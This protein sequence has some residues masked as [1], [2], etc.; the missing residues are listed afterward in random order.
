MALVQKVVELLAVPSSF[1]VTIERTLPI[2]VA[3]RM[4]LAIVFRNLLE[5]ILKHHLKPPIGHMS[6][7]AHMARS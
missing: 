2:I 3:E 5:N 7:S 6:T 1:T 4:L